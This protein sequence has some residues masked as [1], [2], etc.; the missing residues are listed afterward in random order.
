[1]DLLH[2]SK[3]CSDLRYLNVRGCTALSDQGISTLISREVRLESIL[4]CDTSFGLLSVLALCS[5][6]QPYSGTSDQVSQCMAFNLKTLHIGSCKCKCCNIFI[7]PSN[8]FQ[9]ALSVCVGFFSFFLLGLDETDL[10]KLISKTRMLKSLCLRD[11]RLTDQALHSFAGSSL[12][13]LDITNT[14][15]IH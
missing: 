3:F 15:V 1:M 7:F 5:T 13:M 9:T 4:A 14:M 8:I 6:C 11:T 12:M 10:M 2:I